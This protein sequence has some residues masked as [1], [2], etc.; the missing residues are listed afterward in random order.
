MKDTYVLTSSFIT[1]DVNVGNSSQ[2]Y[3]KK[4]NHCHHLVQLTIR[5]IKD[6]AMQDEISISILAQR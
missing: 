6:K 2:I 3:T 5:A 1:M 4:Q